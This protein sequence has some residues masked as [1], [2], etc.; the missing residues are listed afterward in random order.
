MTFHSPSKETPQSSGLV[1]PAIEN[2]IFERLSEKFALFV[3]PLQEF[4][5]VMS[6]CRR[7]DAPGT[8]M[9]IQIPFQFKR[10]E[11]EELFSL[12]PANGADFGTDTNDWYTEETLKNKIV[13]ALAT[14]KFVAT[15]ATTEFQCEGMPKEPAPWSNQAPLFVYRGIDP[16]SSKSDEVFIATPCPWKAEGILSWSNRTGNPEVW[17]LIAQRI[18]SQMETCIERLWASLDLS[19][20]QFAPE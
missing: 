20:D 15:A 16:H 5:I 13:V 17:N 12:R 8:R 4:A 3:D 1:F 7:I 14:Q 6:A 11:R 19:I 18:P 9:G 2:P 10:S